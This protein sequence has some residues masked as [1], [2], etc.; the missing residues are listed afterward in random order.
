MHSI[1]LKYHDPHRVKMDIRWNP[2]SEV[3]SIPGQSTATR[4]II[5]SRHYPI[6]RSHH[7]DGVRYGVYWLECLYE[8][9]D[10][11]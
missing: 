3:S 7:G 11:W 8:R 9:L 10:K 6:P 5:A 4:S 1:D 2:R